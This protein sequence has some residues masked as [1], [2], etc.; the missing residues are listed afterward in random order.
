VQI[1]PAD[2]ST[3]ITDAQLFAIDTNGEYYFFGAI[4]YGRVAFDNTTAVIQGLF[5]D[6][7]RQHG[8]PV[9]FGGRYWIIRQLY[10][11]LTLHLANSADKIFYVP[12]PTP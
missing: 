5:Y 2:S 11:R 10:A 4:P 7:P 12:V 9:L 6:N 8:A 3:Y 1:Q